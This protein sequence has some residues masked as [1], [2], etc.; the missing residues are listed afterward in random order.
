MNKGIV[1]LNE[2]NKTFDVI[3]VGKAIANLSSTEI[4]TLPNIIKNKLNK[5]GLYIYM[6]ILNYQS[7]SKGYVEVSTGKVK[8]WL[9]N[10]LDIFIN[11]HFV[12]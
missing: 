11:W 8:I 12:Y 6:P 1:V 3:V 4:F 10:S 5:Y 9:N 2:T 7:E